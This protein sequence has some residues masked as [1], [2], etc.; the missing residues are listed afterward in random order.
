MPTSDYFTSCNPASMYLLVGAKDSYLGPS[1][2]SGASACQK[3]STSF[4]IFTPPAQF[5]LSKRYEGELQQAG[6]KI[7]FSMDYD[8]ANGAGFNISDAI[9][10]GFTLV[11]Y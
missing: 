7:L 6:D 9:P 10:A 4:A 3:S 11:S 2:M 5:H 8:Y 1:D